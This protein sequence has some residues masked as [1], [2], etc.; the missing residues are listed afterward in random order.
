[1]YE[2]AVAQEL[3]SAHVPLRYY[4]H[5]RR[6][7]VDFLAE[8]GEGG[9]VAIEVK[10]GKD[11][12]LHT[13]LNT[14][15]GIGEYGVE[16]AYVLSEANISVGERAGKPVYYIPL[17]LTPFVIDGLVSEHVDSKAEAARV[18]KTGRMLTIDPPDLS[19]WN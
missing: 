5:S 6:G 15:L 13:A 1:V 7:E 19:A 3:A 4:H 14:L 2:N 9:V 16:G 12:K 10:S 8:T 17:Y 18:A 11:Y